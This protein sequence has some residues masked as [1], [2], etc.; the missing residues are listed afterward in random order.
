MS[1]LTE[2]VISDVSAV[3]AILN[4]GT[5]ASCL[6]TWPPIIRLRVRG[7]VTWRALLNVLTS[8]DSVSFISYGN[9]ATS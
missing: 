9:R 3:R 2:T 1:A 5:I 4:S 8:I 7:R 6:I